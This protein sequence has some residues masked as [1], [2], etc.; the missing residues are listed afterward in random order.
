MAKKKPENDIAGWFDIISNMKD[1]G[2]PKMFAWLL[3][4]GF[5]DEGWYPIGVFSSEEKAHEKIVQEINYRVCSTPSNATL[6][7]EMREKEFSVEELLS[8]YNELNRF[9]MLMLEKVE[10][11]K[12]MRE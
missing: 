9:N 12:D 4:Y 7:K 3:S 2:R 1:V 10:L 5:P 11:D 8:R 6:M